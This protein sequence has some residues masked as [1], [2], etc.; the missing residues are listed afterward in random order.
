M[1]RATP[2]RT[3]SRGTRGPEPRQLRQRCNATKRYARR[4]RLLH[5]S[6]GSGE[7]RS[8]RG[9]TSALQLSPVS[10]SP[11]RQPHAGN[12]CNSGNRRSGQ[13]ASQFLQL[14][15]ISPASQ[16]GLEAARCPTAAPQTTITAI[17]PPT[18]RRQSTNQIQ[19]GRKLQLPPDCKPLSLDIGCRLGEIGTAP[20]S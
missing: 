19:M 15:V 16:S 17:L 9:D 3:S 13:T 6:V 4:V 8:E 14:N 11:H 1:Q 5:G 20:L 10:Q 2:E 18:G 12:T 7:G